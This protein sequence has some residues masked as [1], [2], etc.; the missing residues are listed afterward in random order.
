[1]DDAAVS[2]LVLAVVVVL[3]VWNRLPVGV[4]AL[5]AALALYA[6]GLLSIEEVL[7]GFGDPVVVFIAAL[8]VVGEGVSASGLTTWVGQVVVARAGTRPSRL[9][10]ITML[11]TAGLTALISLN[12]AVAALLPMVV[13][14]AVTAGIAPSRMLMPMA[15]AGSAGSLLVLTG[16]PINIIVSDAA[17]DA[18][19]PAFGFF[20]FALVGVPLVAGTLLLV[21]VLGPR[22]LPDR[23]PEG[24]PR[25]LSQYARTLVEHYELAGG[26]FRVRVRGRSPYVGR[27]RSELEHDVEQRKGLRCLS[28]RAADGRLLGS[29]E[30]VAA[31]AV[32]LVRG[33]AG[34]VNRLVLDQALA[35]GM[36][37]SDGRPAD[38]LLG[39]E[40]GA[41]EVVVPPRSRL[42]GESVFPGMV[43][44]GD[45]VVL[46]VRRR[47]VDRGAGPTV[48]DVGD[49][50][51]VQGTWD[52]LGRNVDSPDVLVVDAPDAVR[53][54][55]VPTGRRTVVAAVVTAA[56][57]ALLAIGSTPAVV[58]ALLAAG[59]MVLL[60][61]VTVD[62]AYRAVPWGTVVL[63]GGLIPLAS[64]IT[65][66]GGADLL[67]D[68]LLA[69]VGGGGPYALLL[70]LFVLTAGL[71]QFISNTATA[72]IVIPVALAAAAE[73]DISPQP[74][75]MLLTVAAAASFLT[76]IAT[77]ANT[78]VMGPG[79]YRFGD[80]WRLGAPVLLWFL[81]VALGLVPLFWPL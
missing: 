3:F 12:G 42:V 47:G 32:L 11:L 65:S 18:G 68:A 53:R 38:A 54:Q 20:E 62:Q 37:P 64:A 79:A 16:T 7:A 57:V 48:L 40:L 75:L 14:L 67:S 28:V 58:P 35:I 72:L 70:A 73:R 69:V 27:P 49:T 36:E 66:S 24:G 10:T 6:T 56:M 51:L 5:G 76:P 74:V 46:A 55:A 22:L 17:V 13:G 80:Y 9:L 59:A 63:V 23:A 25:D 61:V 39:Q 26:L 21:L 19:A 81:V 30:P 8:F 52:A 77:P 44:R 1:M 78:M 2:L 29:E 50:L 4:V 15:F 33:S 43:R 34:T 31:D 45:Q 71:G 41:A 60:R